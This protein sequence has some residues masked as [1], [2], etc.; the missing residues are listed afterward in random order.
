[1]QKLYKEYTV[2][3]SDISE[4]TTD[5]DEYMFKEVMSL[6]IVEVPIGV[7]GYFTQSVSDV[8]GI[9]TYRVSWTQVEQ[10]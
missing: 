5:L 10:V 4:I 1:M 8:N 7:P 2:N 3:L 9:R 6:L